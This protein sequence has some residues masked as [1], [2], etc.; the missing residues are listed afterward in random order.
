MIDKNKLEDSIKLFLEAIGEKVDRDGL[1]DTPKRAANYWLELLEGMNY[2]NEEIANKFNK[3]FKIDKNNKQVIEV[4]NITCFSHCEHHLALMYDLKI[5]IKYI[6]NGKVLGLSKFA[7]I[8]DMV[9]KRLQLQEKIAK[10]IYDILKI[11]LNTDKIQVQ[12]MGKHACMTARGIRSNNSYTETTIG[13][14]D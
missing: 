2:S 8:S 6:P 9:C 1:K 3:T 5:N 14:L 13:N 11:I 7:R 12:I 4:K 10:D